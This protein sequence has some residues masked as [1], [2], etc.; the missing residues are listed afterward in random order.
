MPISML[1]WAIY[2]IAIVFGFWLSY[3]GQPTWPR[4]FGGYV[5]LWILVGILGWRV[6]GSAIK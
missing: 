3:D 6:F 2:I 1:F 5:V 4:R